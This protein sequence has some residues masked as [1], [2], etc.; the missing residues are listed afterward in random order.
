MRPIFLKKNLCLLDL[1]SHG[2]L[3]EA[4]GFLKSY[5]PT[6]FVKVRVTGLDE[7][8]VWKVILQFRAD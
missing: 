6:G 5:R 2:L 1:I 8:E 3:H 4:D 7:N